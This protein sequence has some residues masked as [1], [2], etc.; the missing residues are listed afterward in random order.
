MKDTE[1]DKIL[2]RVRII[3]K[4]SK[5]KKFNQILKNTLEI[6]KYFKYILLFRKTKYKCGKTI[7][8]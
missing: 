3:I 2:I 1:T 5:F 6:P 8:N 7:R 4:I